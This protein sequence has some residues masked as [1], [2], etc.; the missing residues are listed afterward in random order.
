MD[1]R[2]SQLLQIV[3][4][5]LLAWLG[6]KL[7]GRV[8][9]LL[10]VVVVLLAASNAIA[11]WLLRHEPQVLAGIY[12]KPFAKRY[13]DWVCRCT[14]DQPPVAHSSNKPGGELVLHSD[15]DFGIAA[16]RAKQIVR[17]HDQVID[18][19]FSRI[20]EAVTLRQRRSDKGSQPP[21]ASLLLVGGDGVGKRYLSRVLAKLLFRSGG[22]LV[23]ECDRVT[24][25]VLIGSR[26]TP[27][28]LLEA[29]RRQPFQVVIFD[30]IDAASA[31]LIQTLSSIVSR[32]TYRSPN[33]S[34]PI[35]F[36][37]TIIVM[38]TTKAASALGSLA[39][40]SLTE[41]TWHREAM[42]LVV[43]ETLLD[44]SLLNAVSAVFLC[45]QTSDL[46]KAEIIAMLMKKE[47]KAHGVSLSRVDP[48]IIVSQVLQID[49]ATGFGLVPH[50]IKL[51][52]RKPLVAAT[53][54][55]HKLLSLRVRW[56]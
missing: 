16:Y 5:T 29:V 40:K 4:L 31:E 6:F 36:A 39:Q 46:V 14:G 33:S 11:V 21:F 55:N 18:N 22:V 13:V 51:L 19:L 54:H 20:H 3:S 48:E 32:G 15:R 56:S 35:S 53:Q 24:P 43:S 45:Q 44:H 37:N 26:G 30:K 8:H 50:R 9:W 12:S 34:R 23:F 38:T 25:E 1:P 17:G 41:G 27:G 2:L 42:E 28:E 52:L 7:L 47:S 10:A 49:D